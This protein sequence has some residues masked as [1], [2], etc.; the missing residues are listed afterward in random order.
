MSEKLVRILDEIRGEIGIPMVI[1]SGY[2]T[3]EHNKSVGGRRNSSHL[4]GYAADIHCTNSRYR[5]LLISKLIEKGIN[6]IGVYDT[7]IHADVDDKK[8]PNVIW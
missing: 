3:K 6:R 2:R 8:S 5:F 7:F 4:R 1:N